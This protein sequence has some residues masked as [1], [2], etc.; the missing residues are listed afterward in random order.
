MSLQ[1]VQKLA[2]HEHAS[3]TGI[4]LKRESDI[5]MQEIDSV[6]DLQIQDAFRRR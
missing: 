1:T 6:I 5:V 4:Y 3:T 2:G